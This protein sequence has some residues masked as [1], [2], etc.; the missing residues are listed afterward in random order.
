MGL[1]LTSNTQFFLHLAVYFFFAFVGVALSISKCCCYSLQSLR[2]GKHVT[3]IVGAD[4]YCIE[5]HHIPWNT[6]STCRLPF[7]ELY[8]GMCFQYYI[9]GTPLWNSPGLLDSEFLLLSETPDM[10]IQIHVPQE[11]Y[12]TTPVEWKWNSIIEGRVELELISICG[13]PFPFHFHE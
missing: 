10:V 4:M 8:L 12:N 3:T 7:Q 13:A 11:L 6:N 5:M 1:F 2:V 9:Y